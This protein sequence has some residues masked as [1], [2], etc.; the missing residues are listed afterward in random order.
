MFETILL[1]FLAGGGFL[2]L[3]GFA[4]R[5][6]PLE[7]VA[8]AW[9]VGC[10]VIGVSLLIGLRFG[11]PLV[12]ALWFPRV[13][14]GVLVVA[15]LVRGFRRTREHDH[16]CNSADT[17][18]TRTIDASVVAAMIMFGLGLDGVLRGSGLAV[19]LG[20]EA[21]VWSTR[22]RIIWTFGGMTAEALQCI[23][24]HPHVTSPGYPW[25]NPLLQVMVHGYEGEAVGA[26]NRAPIQMFGLVTPFIVFGALR[27]CCRPWTAAILIVAVCT[28]GTYRRALPVAG[29]DLMVAAY[30]VAMTQ[31]W[32]RSSESI[33]SSRSTSD[34]WFVLVGLHGA[35][36]VFAK[37]E[38]ALWLLAL[39]IPF[40]LDFG[41]LRRWCPSGRE[42][43]ARQ[44]KDSSLQSRLSDPRVRRG[45]LSHR[46]IAWA[47]CFT[48]PVAIVAENFWRNAR[49]SISIDR[50]RGA[51]LLH[52]L[53][54]FGAIDFVSRLVEIVR[55]F[56]HQAAIDFEVAHGLVAIAMIIGFFTP[57]PNRAVARNLAG[58][59]WIFAF[60]VCVVYFVSVADVRSHMKWSIGRLL[61]QMLPV[62]AIAVGMWFG[63]REND[64]NRTVSKE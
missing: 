40:L 61:L 1:A 55:I 12:H 21:D 3:A 62:A 32:I 5:F 20:D 24:N 47:A 2:A 60:G 31:A 14:A 37:N 46:L 44:R 8:H 17:R 63:A 29:A 9:L 58:S 38:G 4:R 7:L 19:T 30:A 11:F 59:L 10:V 39:S 13:V 42:D 27:R 28:A 64:C 36:L 26:L 49:S 43:R 6:H 51:E 45:T 52:G 35:G 50:Q 16:R 54:D 18:P 48:L 22:A 41:L 23:A 33:D 56:A 25:L 57:G 53:E 15:S 34:G